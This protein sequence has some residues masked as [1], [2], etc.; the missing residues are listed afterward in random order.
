[1][2]LNNNKPSL[3]TTAM[4]PTRKLVGIYI[5]NSKNSYGKPV[6]L[7]PKEEFRVFPDH[8][9][10]WRKNGDGQMHAIGNWPRKVIS[11][12]EYKDIPNIW[13]TM[14]PTMKI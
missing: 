10:L 13:I 4:D 5:R 9:E 2:Y 11:H 6:F 3:Q 1:M 8:V 12:V 14:N 7:G